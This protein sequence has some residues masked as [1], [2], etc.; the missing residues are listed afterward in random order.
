[1]K[2]NSRASPLGDCYGDH[3]TCRGT[4]FFCNRGKF[5]CGVELAIFFSIRVPHFAP[6]PP[7]CGSDRELL[8]APWGWAHPPPPEVGPCWCQG[9]VFRVSPP[10][11]HQALKRKEEEELLRKQKEAEARLPSES[12]VPG[13]TSPLLDQAFKRKEEEDL[14]RQQK[15]A[16][17]SLIRRSVCCCWVS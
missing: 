4:P 15:Q 12:Q 5:S 3:F 13:G 2:P 6:P 9:L 16:E 8:F 11:L 17:A 14:L 1:M 7:S 10:L